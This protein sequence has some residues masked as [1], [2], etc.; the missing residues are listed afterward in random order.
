MRMQ[1]FVTTGQLERVIGRKLGDHKSNEMERRY[2]IKPSARVLGEDLK[3]THLLWDHED[4]QRAAR[5][6]AERRKLDEEEA[7][8]RLPAAPGTTDVS[9]LLKV[10]AELIAQASS[11]AGSRVRAEAIGLTRTSS[12]R[13]GHRDALG[14][15]GMKRERFKRK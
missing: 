2:G 11:I 3:T 5:V 10:A 7:A 4:I 9:S 13:G 15:H 8:S 6:E 1:T 12:G 14:F